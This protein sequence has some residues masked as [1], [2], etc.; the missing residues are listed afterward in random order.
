ME[1][2]KSKT[3]GNKRMI[4]K[5]NKK[6]PTGILFRKSNLLQLEDII[7]SKNAIVVKRCKIDDLP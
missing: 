3:K 7:K 6:D 4:Y 1:T 5:N 2:K